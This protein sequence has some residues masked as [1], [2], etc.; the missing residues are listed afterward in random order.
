MALR[1]ALDALGRQAHRGSFFRN[2]DERFRDAPLATF[3]SFLYGGRY[4]RGA[5][6]E[7]KAFGALYLTDTPANGLLEV[8][9]M[10]NGVPARLAPRLLLS[11][12]ADLQAVIDLRPPQAHAALGVTIG[13]LTACGWQRAQKRARTVTQEIGAAAFDL[14]LEALLVPSARAAGHYNLV[15]IEPCLLIGSSLQ[16]YVG[17]DQ[18]SQRNARYGLVGS[19]QQR[20]AAT[21]S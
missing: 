1:K 14:G 11:V 9:A 7:R 3:R 20:T 10:V 8:G 16:V 6:Y 2:I 4:N 17:D 5:K 21:D 13:D 19:A 15:V 18:G 12:D